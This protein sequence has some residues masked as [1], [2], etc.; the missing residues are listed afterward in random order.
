TN[1]DRTNYY[2]NVPSSALELALFLESDRMGYLLDAMSPGKVDGQRDVVK[3]ERR[4]GVENQP[5]GQASIT[6]SEMLF[7]DGHPYHWPTIGYMDDLTAASY[8]DV[9]D[10]FKRYYGPNNATLVVAGD[11]DTARTRALVERWF[12]DVNRG[13]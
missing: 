12:S 1:T 5:Y 9:T 2:L 3:N 11:I 8:E 10:F 13:P 6:L 4:Q 7:P